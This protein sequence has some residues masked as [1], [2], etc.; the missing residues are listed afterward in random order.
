MK[1]LAIA[2][3]LIAPLA[4]YCAPTWVRNLRRRWADRRQARFDQHVEIAVTLAM[5]GEE[6]S[7]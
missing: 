4:I 7:S 3:W 5:G 1:W 2:V 6:M